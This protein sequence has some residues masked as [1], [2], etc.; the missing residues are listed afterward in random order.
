[1]LTVVHVYFPLVHIECILVVTDCA[2]CFYINCNKIFKPGMPAWSL[3]IVSVQMF[4]SVCVC[5][6][7]CL[8]VFVCLTLRL[9]ITNGMI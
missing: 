6:C 7:V 9:I 2:I 3:E 8:C 4:E 5:V 1:M